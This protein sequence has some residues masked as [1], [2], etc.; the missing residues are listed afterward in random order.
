MIRTESLFEDLQ[1]SP[2]EPPRF[3]KPSC[4]FV[5]DGGVIQELRQFQIVFPETTVG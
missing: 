5:Q 3:V 2:V 1:S 4:V